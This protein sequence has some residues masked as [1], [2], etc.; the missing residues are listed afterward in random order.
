M[1]TV[2][3]IA[4]RGLGISQLRDLAMVGVKVCFGNFL[5]ASPA[6]RHD[7]ELEA[8]FISATNC[9]STMAITTNGKRLISLAYLGKMNA[10]LELF[11]DTMVAT[12][13]CCRN[14]LGIHARSGI[15]FG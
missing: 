6:L 7:I 8:L 13:T 2:T 15:S 12:S 4:F 10:P 1:G 5:V 11:F 9:M 14:I 3:V